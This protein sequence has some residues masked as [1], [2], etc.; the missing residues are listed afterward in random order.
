MRSVPEEFRTRR[1]RSKEPLG[2]VV[3]AVPRADTLPSCRIRHFHFWPLTLLS[4]SPSTSIL[5]SSDFA[6]SFQSALPEQLVHAGSSL[7]LG[8]RGGAG[9][10][11]CLRGECRG[12]GEW[13]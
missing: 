4:T 13:S 8:C 2:P 6:F 9:G 10:T 7:L 11:A 12:I 5:P 1:V 3:F